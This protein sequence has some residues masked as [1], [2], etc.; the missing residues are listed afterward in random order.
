L[1]PSGVQIWEA[2]VSL[3]FISGTLE[4][5]AKETG[6]GVKT[7]RDACESGDIPCYW[8]GNKRILRAA[9]LDEWV[10]TL[11]TERPS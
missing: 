3:P 9:D 11:S 7:L 6:I 2:E 1:I 4:R 5:A 10:Q 8:A